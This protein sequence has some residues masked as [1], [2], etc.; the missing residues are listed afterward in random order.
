MLA[1]LCL[2]EQPSTSHI[3]NT[4]QFQDPAI[5]SS[6][7]YDSSGVS[8]DALQT[9]ALTTDGL[10]HQFPYPSPSLVSTAHSSQSMSSHYGVATFRGNRMN[11]YPLEG[12]DGSLVANQHCEFFISISF[13]NCIGK[14]TEQM[15]LQH[16]IYIVDEGRLSSIFALS[17][18]IIFALKIGLSHFGM[19]T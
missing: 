7:Q 3:F 16:E 1:Y 18:M 13:G 14:S 8:F 5:M 2:T 17:S 11:S 12:Y 9:P 15:P 6:M 10:S 4:N 19:V